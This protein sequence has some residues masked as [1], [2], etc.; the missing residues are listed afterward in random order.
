[1]EWGVDMASEHER[2]LCEVVFQKPVI[3]Y[4]YPCAIKAFYMRRND[5][6]TDGAPGPTCAAM[7]VLVPGVGELIGGS[8]REERHDV[9]T[10]GSALPGSRTSMNSP[11]SLPRALTGACGD[12]QGGRHGPCTVLVVP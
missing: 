8:V 10:L 5:P 4:N 2:Y 12:H 11:E 7:D 3:V 6:G 1:M 9:R